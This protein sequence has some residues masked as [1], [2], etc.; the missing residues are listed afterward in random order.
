MNLSDVRGEDALDAMADLLDPVTKIAA[1]KEFA[2]LYQ[3]KPLLFSV[4]YALKNHKKE[5][6]EILAIMNCED[7]DTFNPGFWELPKMVFEVL[8]DENVRSLFQSQQMKKSNDSSFAVMQN[9]KETE[10]M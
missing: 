7:P 8:D 5:I 2:N 1:D 9:T 4:K 3:S 10:E 6:L